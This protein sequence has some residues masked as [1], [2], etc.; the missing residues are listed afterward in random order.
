MNGISSLAVTKLDILDFLDFIKICVSYKNFEYPPIFHG[1]WK[2][3]EPVYKTFV[4]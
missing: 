2:G 3:I 1:D 4:G